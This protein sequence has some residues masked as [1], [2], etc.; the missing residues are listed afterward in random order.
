MKENQEIRIMEGPQ[1]GYNNETVLNA[2]DRV[3][4]V[5]VN[6]DKSSFRGS[7]GMHA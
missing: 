2:A 6:L 1:G 3:R 7:L 5:S 4:Q